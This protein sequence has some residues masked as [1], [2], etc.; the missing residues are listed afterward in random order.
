MYILCIPG[1]SGALRH[2]ISKA[3]QLYDPNFRPALKTGI[4]RGFFIVGPFENDKL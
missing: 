4:C 2:G 3:L 1:Q